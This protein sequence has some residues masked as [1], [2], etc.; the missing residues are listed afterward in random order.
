MFELLFQNFLIM[1]PYRTVVLGTILQ[2]KHTY[3][4][5]STMCSTQV[6]TT[7]VLQVSVGSYIGSVFHTKS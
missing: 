5:C 4:S 3:M 2:N 7:L 6:G 1:I